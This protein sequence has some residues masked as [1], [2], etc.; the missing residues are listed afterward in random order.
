MIVN[1]IEQ[2]IQLTSLHIHT[3]GYIKI[4]FLISHLVVLL[5]L[6]TL[7]SIFVIVT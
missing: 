5:K 4:L 3:Q 2:S 7:Y 6:E 1:I